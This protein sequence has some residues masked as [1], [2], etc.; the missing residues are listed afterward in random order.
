MKP[1]HHIVSF[2]LG[3]TLVPGEVENERGQYV[4]DGI[5]VSRQQREKVRARSLHVLARNA[6]D[7]SILAHSRIT[8]LTRIDPDGGNVDLEDA[9]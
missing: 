1:H 6:G 5:L 7:G 2:P 3:M 9:A 8:G 4:I